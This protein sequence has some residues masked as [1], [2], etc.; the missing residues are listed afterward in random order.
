[1]R[2]REE[3]LKHWL[4]Q[5]DGPAARDLAALQMQLSDDDTAVAEARQHCQAEIYEFQQTLHQQQQATQ[6]HAH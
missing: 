4:D 1:M 6:L 2:R 5:Q 3:D